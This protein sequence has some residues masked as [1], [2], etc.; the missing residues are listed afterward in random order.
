[1]GSGQKHSD[2]AGLVL[3]D[4]P[5]KSGGV[6]TALN[7]LRAVLNPVGE[8]DKLTVE[9]CSALVSIVGDVWFAVGG[10]ALDVAGHPRMLPAPRSMWHTAYCVVI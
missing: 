6:N 2:G 3:A 5:L 4:L 1:M 9:V 7:S 10:L 8:G